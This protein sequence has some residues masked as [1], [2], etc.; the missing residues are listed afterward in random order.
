MGRPVIGKDTT[1][2]HLTHG[3]WQVTLGFDSKIDET[4]SLANLHPMVRDAFVGFIAAMIDE[5]ENTFNV[6]PSR[7]YTTGLSNVQNADPTLLPR[8]T[9]P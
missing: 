1:S 9:D 3:G 6:D 7:I 5:I 2:L 4:T 8:R